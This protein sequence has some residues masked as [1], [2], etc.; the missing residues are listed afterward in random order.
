MMMNSKEPANLLLRYWIVEFW[1]QALQILTF[2]NTIIVFE[3]RWLH[4][5]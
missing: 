5:L 2:F 3:I 1:S 4:Y